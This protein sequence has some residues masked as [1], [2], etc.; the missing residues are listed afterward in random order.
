MAYTFAVNTDE[1][2]KLKTTLKNA[3]DIMSSGIED[4]Y[5]EIGAMGDNDIWGGGSYTDFS[6]GALKYKSALET[7][8]GVLEA[9]RKELERAE[10]DA[11]PL[12]TSI[13]EAINNMMNS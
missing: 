3:E 7:L 9:F 2:E 8:P 12:N 11:S 6:N 13:T 10:K 5:S 4:I 1:I